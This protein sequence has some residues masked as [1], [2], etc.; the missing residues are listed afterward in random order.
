[1]FDTEWRQHPYICLLY[2]WLYRD[3]SKDDSTLSGVNPL[4][5]YGWIYL[6]LQRAL[7]KIETSEGVSIN[8]ILHNQHCSS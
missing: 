5:R 3:S 7:N 6:N 2:K 4:L 1:M 8:D